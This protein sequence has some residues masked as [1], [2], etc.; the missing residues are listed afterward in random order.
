MKKRGL[1]ELWSRWNFDL[2]LLG[3]IVT[4]KAVFSNHLQGIYSSTSL[5]DH[6]KTC[7]CGW[8]YYNFSWTKTKFQNCKP[9]PITI[10]I[11][12]FNFFN[13]MYMCTC[14]C[15]RERWAETERQ[16]Q[17]DCESWVLSLWS[18]WEGIGFPKAWVTGDTQ[19]SEDVLLVAS[20]S[21]SDL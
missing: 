16:R 11:K 20:R 4:V 1:I 8:F 5:K 7:A 2:N 21:K 13:S 12:C 6:L 15:V 19:V 17:R 10:K 3:K 18:S 9:D 14:V